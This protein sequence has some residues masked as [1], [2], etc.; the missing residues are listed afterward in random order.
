MQSNQELAEIIFCYGLANGN[1]RQ[2]RRLYIEKYPDRIAPHHSKFQKLYQQLCETGNLSSN[3]EHP[4]RQRHARTVQVEENV[5]HEVYENKSAS[6]RELARTVNVSH[7]SVWR[8]LNEQLLYPFH[9]QKTQHLTP[10]DY[11]RR[12]EYCSFLRESLNTDPEFFKKILFSDESCFTRGGVL[13]SHNM[14]IWEEENPHGNRPHNYQ[15]RFSVNVWC[16]MIGNHLI[17]PFF[18]DGRLTGEKYVEFLQNDLNN[19]L[20]DVPLRERR[21]MWF[22]HDGAP[23]HTSR[24]AR[25]FLNNR[26]PNRVIGSNAPVRWPPRSPDL[27]PLDFFL[28]GYLKYLVY[29]TPVQNVEDLKD[30]IRR[31]CDFIR[32]NSDTL[33]PK[34]LES[35]VKRVDLCLEH[36][37]GIFECL[38]F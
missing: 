17:G 8:I 28:W 36:N 27:N 13:N 21:S 6:T 3:Y 14:H 26:Y 2:A 15:H 38:R 32:Q 35:M 19:L 31:A 23:P 29:K 10:E 34:A 33:F 37:G 30:R 22:M 4:G 9:I 20:E 24:I 12:V 5:L 18:I 7:S 25:D 1:S 16:G 11:P